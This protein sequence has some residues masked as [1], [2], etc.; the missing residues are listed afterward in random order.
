MHTLF[1]DKHKDGM[2]P[3]VWITKAAHLRANEVDTHQVARVYRQLAPKRPVLLVA[4]I[5]TT[6]SLKFRSTCYLR[7]DSSST[8][9]LAVAWVLNYQA[10][11][12]FAVPSLHPPFFLLPL[13]FPFEC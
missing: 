3:Q 2:P 13:P 8:R 1:V 12:K 10:D 4:P 6:Y 11:P 5:R 9:S 7:L